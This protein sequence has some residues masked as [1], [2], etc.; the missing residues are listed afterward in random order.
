MVSSE[1]IQPYS[2]SAQAPSRVSDGASRSSLQVYTDAAID[3]RG[4]KHSYGIVVAD[5]SGFV[6][7]GVAKPCIGD[8]CFKDIVKL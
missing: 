8:G 3:V 6:K 7:V 4:Q 5:D 1:I 2:V